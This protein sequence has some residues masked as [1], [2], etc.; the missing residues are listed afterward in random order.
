MG[1]GAL[2]VEVIREPAG[3]QALREDW[4]AL[5]AD[6]RA[7]SAAQRFAY[8][9]AAWTF[10]T[11]P[12]QRLKVITV[13]RDG[14]LVGLW[15]LGLRRSGL[16]TVARHLGTDEGGEYAEPLIAADTD[17]PAQV[18]GAL[19]AAA[20]AEGDILEIHN[21]SAGSPMLGVVE[22]A[23]R[24]KVRRPMASPVTGFARWAS[25]DAWV[26]GRSR[27]FRQGLRYDRKRL[28]TRGDLMFREVDP[29]AAGA[30]VDWIVA[31]KVEWLDRQG[32]G[33]SWLRRPETAQFYR[34]LVGRPD[35]GVL[36]F[37]L[38]LDG[39]TIAGGLCL[40]S[41]GRLEYYVT[42]YDPALA[43]FSPGNLLI[44]DLAR[45][46]IARGDDLDFR[47]TSVDYKLRWSDRT[48][49][50]GTYIVPL[51]PL[52]VAHAWRLQG[53]D[54]FRSALAQVRSVAKAH[55]PEGV[56]ARLRRLARRPRTA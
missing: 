25:W 30:F 37:A 7:I 13:R 9:E 49:P 52:G 33:R 10:R 22:A 29:A 4:R 35:S 6:G 51:S 2:A 21:L 15:P 1:A 19:F 44:E 39:R 27:S 48:E 8:V 43:A 31:R 24:T 38:D 16:L 11:Q 53:R 26:A 42:A 3:L 17:T 41:A 34:A 20:A 23:R 47:L 32:I 46:C 55:L 28:A 18:A 40:R 54:S 5:E 14:R 50:F 12:Q 36:G 45:W 56:V